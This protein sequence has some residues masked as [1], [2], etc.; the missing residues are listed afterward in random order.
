M[1]K[2]YHFVT[3]PGHG[4]L[5][6]DIAELERLG[7]Q[8]QISHYSYQRRGI[9]YLE[10][11]TDMGVF[12]DAKQAC[13][14]VVKIKQFNRKHR[15]HIRNYPIYNGHK[16]VTRRNARTGE[17]FQERADKPFHLS[18]SSESYWCS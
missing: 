13:G 9:A 16:L 6:V 15:T 11:D 1:K 12:M 10:E 7:I 5:K 4:W 18:P 8:D 14:E 3:D 2:V 17:L